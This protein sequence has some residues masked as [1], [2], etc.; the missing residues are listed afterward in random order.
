MLQTSFTVN[1]DAEICVRSVGNAEVQHWKAFLSSDVADYHRW[2]RRHGNGL[3]K[4]MCIDLTGREPRKKKAR[5]WPKGCSRGSLDLS[6]LQT[7][8]CMSSPRHPLLLPAFLSAL[9]T[10]LS[11]KDCKPCKPSY[12]PTA[13]LTCVALWQKPLKPSKMMKKDWT[14]LDLWSL[15]KTMHSDFVNTINATGNETLVISTHIQ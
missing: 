10:L 12:S 11:N 6:P 8:S 4:A 14:V 1:G 15:S 3:L 7:T 13:L 2:G 5:T 9:Y